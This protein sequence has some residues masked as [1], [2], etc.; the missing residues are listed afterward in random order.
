MV[1]SLITPLLLQRP[2]SGDFHFI[3][4]AQRWADRIPLQCSRY[5][6]ITPIWTL[7][8]TL[9]YLVA[10]AILLAC[11][12]GAQPLTP[13]IQRHSRSRSIGKYCPFKACFCLVRACVR[14][15]T[16][17]SPTKLGLGH[18]LTS[19]LCYLLLHMALLHLL[20]CL[21]QNSLLNPCA[22]L[23]QLQLQSFPLL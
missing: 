14:C 23:H 1:Q 16:G 5:R 10:A 3:K 19:H 12:P 9:G 6:H 11:C 20:F 21:T 13:A 8:S 18:F 2:P 15:V 7:L 4:S 22:T 17:G